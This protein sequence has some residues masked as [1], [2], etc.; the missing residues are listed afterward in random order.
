MYTVE[1]RVVYKI[2]IESASSLD[3]KLFSQEEHKEQQAKNFQLKVLE[4]RA[5]KR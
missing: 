5:N 2:H 4:L 3:N 1:A